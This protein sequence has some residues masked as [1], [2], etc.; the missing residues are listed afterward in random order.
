MVVDSRHSS[1][2]S[3]Y[4]TIN[5]SFSARANPETW[6]LHKLIYTS[7]T[8]FP[9]YVKENGVSPVDLLGVIR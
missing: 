3:N 2:E 9:P 8:A 5:S 7:M 1:K 6:V 4:F